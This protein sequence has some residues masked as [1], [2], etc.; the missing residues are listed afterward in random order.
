MA[1]PRIALIVG[2]LSKV[3]LNR[4]LAMALAEAGRSRL[5][6]EFVEIRDLPLYDRDRDADLPGEAIRFKQAIADADGVL[7]VTPE[8]N[9]S[10]PSALKNAIDWASRPYGQSAWRGKK[11]AI[12]GASTGVLGTAIAQ[13]HLR[14]I[15]AHL[16]VAVLAQPEL[17]VKVTDELI[18]PDGRVL[19]SD[20]AALL[21]RFI[22][23]LADLVG[24][25]GA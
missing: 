25:G 19:S 22:D 10:V 12:A 14:I 11:A 24:S 2:S 7:I 21:D 8:Y 13:S 1:R 5:D 3:S 6:F 4:R 17:Y 20:F 15:L 23:R 9:R 18:S 16:D